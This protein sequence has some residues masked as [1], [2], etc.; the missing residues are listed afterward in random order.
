ML[1]KRFEIEVV[2][3]SRLWLTMES[4]PLKECTIPEEE[5]GNDY[6]H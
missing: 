6:R 1:K 2:I 4:F 5:T 3:Y